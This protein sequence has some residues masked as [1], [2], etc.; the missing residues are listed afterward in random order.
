MPKR[1]GGGAGVGDGIGWDGIFWVVCVCMYGGLSGC[2]VDGVVLGF[3]CFQ[4]GGER[5]D[6][7]GANMVSE[8]LGGSFERT[9]GNGVRVTYA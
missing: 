7:G 9:R 2:G 8:S 1:E 6:V 5:T 4:V 3:F